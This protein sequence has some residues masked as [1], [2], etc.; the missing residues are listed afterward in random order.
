MRKRRRG[1]LLRLRP[2]RLKQRMPSK[3]CAQGSKADGELLSPARA[4]RFRHHRK[5]VSASNGRVPLTGAER[6]RRWRSQHP[7]RAAAGCRAYRDRKRNPAQK[8][9]R[10][11]SQ[12]FGI[13]V[14]L[15]RRV[16]LL[17]A[18]GARSEL[19]AAVLA[20]SPRRAA[21]IEAVAARPATTPATVP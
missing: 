19:I 3:D 5:A 20:R 15:S 13:S 7:E 4:S 17:R 10:D 2:L 16:I 21:P 11:L 14:Q 8:L 6:Q 18:A 9:A 1:C 12:E